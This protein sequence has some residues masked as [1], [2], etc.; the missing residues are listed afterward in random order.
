VA[1]GRV[2]L[3]FRCRPLLERGGIGSIDVRVV[4]IG[5][6]G[7]A[8]V[9]VSRDGT[10]Y[11]ALGALAGDSSGFDLSNAGITAVRFMRITGTEGVVMID[12]V[13]SVNP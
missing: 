7:R 6:S 12:A 2:E 13:T 10:R 9:E 8:D 11:A 3:T 1:G 4:V 5:N